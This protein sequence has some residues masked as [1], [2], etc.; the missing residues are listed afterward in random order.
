MA[1]KSA[2]LV[3]RVHLLSYIEL[4]FKA[5]LFDDSWPSTTNCQCRELLLFSSS[6]VYTQAASLLTLVKEPHLL[7]ATVT[8]GSQLS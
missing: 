8:E 4:G 5:K 6:S 7:V 3:T 1:A 2:D